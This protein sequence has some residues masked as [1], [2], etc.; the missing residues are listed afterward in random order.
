M[1]SMFYNQSGWISSV[2]DFTFWLKKTLHLKYN[3]IFLWKHRRRNTPGS[4]LDNPVFVYIRDFLI[5]DITYVF[6]IFGRS[7]QVWRSTYNINKCV[8]STP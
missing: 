8:Y 7:E 4:G 6:I 2:N 3:L 1:T 5:S